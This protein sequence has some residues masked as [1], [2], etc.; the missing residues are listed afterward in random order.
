MTPFNPK[1]V[2]WGSIHYFFLCRAG[3][4]TQFAEKCYGVLTHPY[5]YY[6]GVGDGYNF[7]QIRTFQLFLSRRHFFLNI[8]SPI[9]SQGEG[10]PYMIF[11]CRSGYF[12]QFLGKICFDT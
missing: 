4:F 8:D 7:V 6:H 12:M 9:L 5:L 2:G 10:V 3:Y 11:L 1:V